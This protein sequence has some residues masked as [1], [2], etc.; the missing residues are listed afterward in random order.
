MDVS[1]L[2]NLAIFSFYYE[3]INDLQDNYWKKYIEAEQFG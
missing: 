1:T 2:H 3:I